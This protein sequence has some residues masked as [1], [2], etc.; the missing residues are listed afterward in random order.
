ML[1]NRKIPELKVDWDYSDKWGSVMAWW[2]GCATALCFSGELIPEE[3]EYR[4]ALDFHCLRLLTDEDQEAIW[5]VDAVTT[6]QLAWED[7]R[8]L[9]FALMRYAKILDGRGESY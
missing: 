9:G 4:A 2:F 7:V 3:W 6:E 5:I 1:N 8:S